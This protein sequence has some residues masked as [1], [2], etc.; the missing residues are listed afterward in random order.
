[1]FYHTGSRIERIRGQSPA[2]LGDFQV[3]FQPLTINQQTYSPSHPCAV[4]DLHQGN[5]ELFVLYASRNVA[6][7]ADCR[8]RIA[9]QEE[10]AWTGAGDGGNHPDRIYGAPNNLVDVPSTRDG[11]PR[12]LAVGYDAFGIPAGSPMKLRLRFTEWSPVDVEYHRQSDWVSIDNAALC[13]GY[14]D[15]P[16]FFCS[17]LLEVYPYMKL[18]WT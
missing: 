13:G 3:V 11:V 4:R 7:P 1:M 17:S 12:R 16:T 9:M 15:P 8:T 10:W 2:T 18:V 5:D 6:A 14:L